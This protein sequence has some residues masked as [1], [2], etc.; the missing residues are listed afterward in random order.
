MVRRLW[1]LL[2]LFAGGAAL[3]EQ[4]R[5]ELRSTEVEWGKPLRGHLVYQ[6]PLSEMTVDYT[7]WQKLLLVDPDYQE[8]GEDQQGRPVIRQALRL[9]PRRPGALQLPSL[10][11]GHSYS[12]P[13]WIKVSAPT[14]DGHKIQVDYH[15]PDR[16][17]W[18]GQP[19]LATAIVTTT[20][21]RV[22]VLVD[23][24]RSPWV[25]ITALESE[26]RVIGS[27]Q[28]RRIQHRFGWQ[29]LSHQSGRIEVELP[30]LRYHLHGRDHR[31]FQLPL[32]Q[33]DVA[34]VPE[35]IPPT[36]AVGKPRLSSRIAHEDG[37]TYWRV[38]V[39][40]GS[41][42]ASGLPEL[43]AQLAGLAGVTPSRIQVSHSEDYVLGD[44]RSRLD[45]RVALPDW[46]LPVVDRPQL[47][48]RYFDPQAGELAELVHLLPVVW[49]VPV[50]FQLLLAAALGLLLWPLLRRLMA[51]FGRQR[52]RHALAR[53]I[54]NASDPQAL[55]QLL[56]Q[57]SGKQSLQQWLVDSSWGGKRGEAAALA[58]SLNEACFGCLGEIQGEAWTSMLR[59]AQ[60]L[61]S[62]APV[63]CA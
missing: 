50:W 61:V 30:S 8:L 43:A 56:L 55:R 12:A 48:L 52:R 21:E 53:A 39:A 38:E 7:P 33:L 28:E 13:L 1:P 24:P 15:Y 42:L 45:Y 22:R 32:L 31:R 46:Q 54:S 9:H 41:P 5:L 47:R 62:R 18:T 11:M 17:L 20:D 37:Q 60:G 49:R 59:K 19:A 51:A 40:A 6:G 23:P 16:K 34:A 35:Y 63:C 44:Y 58:A 26:R 25:R 3:A 57:A 27:G 14:V 4:L 2:L 10:K 29:L 36:T